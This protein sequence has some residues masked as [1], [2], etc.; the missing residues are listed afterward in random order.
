MPCFDRIIKNHPE[1]EQIAKG[2]GKLWELGTPAD[3][4]GDIVFEAIKNDIFYIFTE[5]G[6]VWKKGMKNRFDGILNDYNK[7]RPIIK[8]LNSK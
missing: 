4:S 3:Q 2:A 5:I 1:V 7:C 8:E 6:L